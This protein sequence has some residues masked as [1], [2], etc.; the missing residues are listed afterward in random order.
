MRPVTDSLGAQADPVSDTPER[1]ELR[2]ELRRLIAATSPADQVLRLDEK[3]QFDDELF[4]RLRQLGVHAVGGHPDHGGL[5]DIRDQIAVIEELAAG[6]T[7][8]AVYMVVHYMITHILSTNG[9]PEQRAEWLDRLHT[10]GAKMSFA[11]SEPAGGTDIARVMRTTARRDGDDWLLSGQKTWISGALRADALVVL[12]RTSAGEAAAVDGVTMFL[13]PAGSPGLQVR[14]LATVAVHGLDTCEVFFD[15]VRVPGSAV[16][17]TVGSGFRQV[18]A[19]LNRERVNAAAGAI[20]AATGALD[21]AVEYAREREAFG[22]TLGSFQA[23]QHRLVDGALAI[24]AARSL[25]ARAAAVEAAGGRA[26]LLSSMAKIAASEAAVKV[27]QDGMEILGG[28]GFSRE[29][30][31]QRW[32]RDVRLWVFAPLANDMVRNYLGERLLGLPRSF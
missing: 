24:E 31:M 14:E 9:S 23:V 5:G 20:G 26:D 12:A 6:P 30:P 32:F 22:S 21:A 17:G 11:L 19:T 16:I 3:E 15:D 13:V 8:M 25:L 7:S 27:T 29:F 28:A 18:V 2:A 1:A 10:G 4:E